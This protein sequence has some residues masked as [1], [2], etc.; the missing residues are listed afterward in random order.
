MA[1]RFVKKKTEQT[2]KPEQRP[3]RT[4]SRNLVSAWMPACSEFYYNYME[5]LFNTTFR[6]CALTIKGVMRRC[7]RFGQFLRRKLGP[8]LGAFGASC[9]SFWNEILR[10]FKTPLFIIRRG[11]YLIQRNYYM[12]AERQGKLHGFTVSVKTIL[13]GASNN[14][15]LIHRGL[16]YVLPCVMVTILIMVVVFTQNL[17]FAVQVSYNGQPVG[18]IQD[19]TVFESAEQKMQQ[20]IVYVEGEDVIDIIPQYSVSL[21]SKNEILDDEAL[22][23]NMIR[24]SNLDIIEA[25]GFYIGDQFY[26]AV[27]DPEALTEALESI[28]DAYRSDSS[29]ETVEFE[30][31]YDFRPGLYLASSVVDTNELIDMVTSQKQEERTYT[32]QSGDTPYEIA[33]DNNISLNELVAL[34]PGILENCMPGD[35]VKL[36]GSVPFMSVKVS[37]TLTYEESIPYE[38]VEVSDKKYLKGTKVTTQEGENGTRQVTATVEYVNGVEVGRTVLDSVVTKEPVEKHVTVGSAEPTVVVPSGGGLA[39]GTGSGMFINPCPSGYVSQEFGHAGHK[40]MDI[41]SGY[42]NP[43]YASAGG[44]VILARWYSG[45]GK[46]VM[47]DHGNGIVTLYGHASNLYVSQ[48][49]VVA[50]GQ[51]IAA[52]GST[53]WSSGNHCH[54]EIRVNGQTVNPRR[55]L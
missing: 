14:R 33:Q 34:N 41:A 43:I 42:G 11:F 7:K 31:P 1:F 45:Y 32:I 13:E 18:Y 44:T 29:N 35:T 47:I 22:A 17:T 15:R 4:S 38:T 19:E 48:G 50:Q 27:Q 52:V 16:N 36:Q 25:Q 54:F 51:P 26:G 55:Y 30:Q 3:D 23:D 39:P 37:R 53:G 28:L 24:L 46:C 8:Q 20:R 21:V 6:I 5:P 12:A 40:G 9:R 2:A 49:Q 10:G